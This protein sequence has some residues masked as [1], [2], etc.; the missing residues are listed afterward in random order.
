[1]AEL[2]LV[3][4][5]LEN[6]PVCDI[7]A[8]EIVT[9]INL[10]FVYPKVRDGYAPVCCLDV[11][12]NIVIKGDTISLDGKNYLV[13]HIVYQEKSLI[14]TETGEDINVTYDEPILLAEVYKKCKLVKKG[15]Q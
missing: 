9:W 5:F 10:R 8:R 4:E 14:A 13:D 2:E 6:L 11:D 1:M 7:F 3:K 12:D 15:G